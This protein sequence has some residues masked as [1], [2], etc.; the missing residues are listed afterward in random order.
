MIEYMAPCTPQEVFPLSTI[1]AICPKVMQGHQHVKQQMGIS[2]QQSHIP[3][4]QR[5]WVDVG[6]KTT[7][8]YGWAYPGGGSDGG[9]DF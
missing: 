8:A 2:T 1:S 6:G 3:L 5:V 9:G 4:D 7:A